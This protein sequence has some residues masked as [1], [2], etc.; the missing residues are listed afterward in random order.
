MLCA[1]VQVNREISKD[2]TLTIAT[3]T[4]P[5]GEERKSYTRWIDT[6]TVPLTT[7][8]TRISN[9]FSCHLRE[10]KEKKKQTKHAGG[11]KPVKSFF[12]KETEVVTQ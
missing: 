9:I 4:N 8:R 12:A 1:A 2:I 5:V 10:K 11:E 3:G 7:E 6:A